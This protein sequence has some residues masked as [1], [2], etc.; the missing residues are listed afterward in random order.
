MRGIKFNVFLNYKASDKYLADWNMKKTL[1]KAKRLPFYVESTSWFQV[2]SD[3]L[4]IGDL[5]DKMVVISIKNRE[6][7]NS[8]SSFFDNLWKNTK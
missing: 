5:S 1:S 4:D 3:R 2:Y 8:F 7:A 6:I